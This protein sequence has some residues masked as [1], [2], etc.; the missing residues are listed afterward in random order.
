MTQ[1]NTS[2]ETNVAFKDPVLDSQK[3][4]R[5]L[6][7][8]MA[9][10]GKVHHM[11]D[12]A[13]PPGPLMPAAAAVCLTLLDLDT[14]LWLDFGSARPQVTDYL[15]FA[16][17]CP[18]AGE[19]DKAAFALILDPAAM[20]RLSSFNQGS[21]EYPDRSV[22]L[23][24]QVDELGGQ[25]GKTLKGPGIKE[26]ARLH[27]SGLPPEFWKQLRDNRELFPLGVDLILASRHEVACLPR[28]IRVEG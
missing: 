16:T 28:T 26:T 10:P 1:I 17:G 15:R 18:L 11:G 23:I 8:A 22:T 13:R 20:P 2:M 7:D 12:I 6:L 9:R 4:F 3:V 14:P 25:A 27:A 19:P 24:I 21:A 5:H